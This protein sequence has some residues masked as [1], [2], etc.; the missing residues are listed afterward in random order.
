MTKRQEIFGLLSIF[1]LICA[2]LLLHPVTTGTFVI[3]DGINWLFAIHSNDQTAAWTSIL[4]M[5]SH[6]AVFALGMYAIHLRKQRGS[7]INTGV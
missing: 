4:L 6:V 5:V 2:R 1:F 7:Q 3:I